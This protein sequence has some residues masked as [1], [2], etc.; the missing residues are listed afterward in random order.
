MRM[1]RLCA[2]ERNDDTAERCR[3]CGAEMAP[4]EDE[5]ELEQDSAWFHYL[6]VPG[7]GTIELVPGRALQIG[8]DPRSELVIPKASQDQLATLFWTDDYDEATVK[9]MGA[10]E[11]VKVNDARI[12]GTRNLKG[13]EEIVV[14][15][16]R[17]TYL[18]RA[19]P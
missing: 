1:C 11:G 9:E 15:P 12:T 3:Q 2:F 19:K 18:R 17:M 7:I 16:L 13:G 8:K 4:I 6:T 5:D 14:G 10:A